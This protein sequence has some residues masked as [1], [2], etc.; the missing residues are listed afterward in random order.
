MKN[1]IGSLYDH[2]NKKYLLRQKALLQRNTKLRSCFMTTVS[3]IGFLIKFCHSHT[4]QNDN[5]AYM[6]VKNSSLIYHCIDFEKA[7]LG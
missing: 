4:T 7:Y 2:L 1:Q 3:Q 6:L 5:V